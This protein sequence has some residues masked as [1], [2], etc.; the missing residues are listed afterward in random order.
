MALSDESND[1]EEKTTSLSVQAFSKSSNADILA[2]K[3]STDDVD[4]WQHICSECGDI[5][6]D[7]CFINVA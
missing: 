3:A 5:I 1:L 6:P 7:G 2:G 4:S